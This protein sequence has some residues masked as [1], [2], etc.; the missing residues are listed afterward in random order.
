[1]LRNWG[2]TSA[3]KSDEIKNAWNKSFF[4][5]YGVI[6]PAQLPETHRKYALSRQTCCA[7]DNTPFDSTWEIY[8]YEFCLLHNLNI[9]L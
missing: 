9:S 1:M 4:D 5:K 7:S 3:M 6:N 8:F 2:V